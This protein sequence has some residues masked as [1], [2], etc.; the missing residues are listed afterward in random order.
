MNTILAGAVGGLTTFLIH[1][2]EL[3]K[4]NNGYNLHSYCDG[5]LAGIVAIS[6]D[7]HNIPLAVSLV[8]GLLAGL[9]LDGFKV[10]FRKL[11]ID[12]VAD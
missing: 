9:V 2:F 12:D 1:W 4:T 3:R 8:V 11:K 5:I 6:G 7:P 10:L